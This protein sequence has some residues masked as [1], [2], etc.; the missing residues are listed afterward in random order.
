MQRNV[1]VRQNKQE[2]YKQLNPKYDQ[3]LDESLRHTGTNENVDKILKTDKITSKN[4][5]DNTNHIVLF[6]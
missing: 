4:I 3:K 2:S 6:E 1:V 5:V